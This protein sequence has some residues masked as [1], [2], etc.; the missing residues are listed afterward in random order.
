[1]LFFKVFIFY[2]YENYLNH[3]ISIKDSRICLKLSSIFILI[4]P[5]PILILDS[6]N[7]N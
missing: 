7:R 6:K 1:M 4:L 2:D 5:S 3:Y